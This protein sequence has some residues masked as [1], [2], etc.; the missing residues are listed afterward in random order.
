MK[1]GGGAYAW[2]AETKV[3]DHPDDNYSVASPN[4]PTPWLINTTANVGILLS[5]WGNGVGCLLG[6]YG[7][8]TAMVTP[9]LAIADEPALTLGNLKVLIIGS[10]GLEGNRS[11]LFKNQ[12]AS[13]VSNGGTLI[14]LTQPYGADFWALPGNI[15]GYG[16][17]E[18]QSCQSNSV[19]IN[20]LSPVFASQTQ[21]LL[22]V[23]VDG[24]FT[25][26]PANT[27]ILLKRAIN[28][29]PAL[30]QYQYGSG[31]VIAGTMYSDWAYGEAQM[32][33]TEGQLIRD[34][35][36]YALNPSLP[37]PT[38]ITL[39]GYIPGA[40]QIWAE[41]PSELVIAGQTVPFTIYV[42]NN[43]NKDFVNGNIEVGDNHV[44]VTTLSSVTI[45]A[46]T[47]S[48]FTYT[49]NVNN[50]SR[51]YFGLYGSTVNPSN[52][53]DCSDTQFNCQKGMTV[54][55]AGA[56]RRSRRIKAAQ[57]DNGN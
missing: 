23:C 27:Q 32:S 18:D 35:V 42:K 47:Q 41:V 5:G 21:A 45:Y 29:M 54:V 36:L 33:T 53:C 55:P 3:N 25:S 43:T 17:D 19:Y 6:Q 57:S 10:A 28:G 38:G 22:N 52:Y 56:L 1:A 13:F 14:C 44:Y 16:W 48:T 34:M 51:L 30:I 39:N 4:Y 9:S 46:N 2:S 20:Q 15:G 50:T 37:N 7:L 12:L 31:T 26:Y 40:L 49:C 8:Q 11:Q 24:Y